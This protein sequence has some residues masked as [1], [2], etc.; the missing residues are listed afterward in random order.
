VRRLFKS[1]ALDREVLRWGERKGRWRRIARGVYG[2]GP[3]DPTPLDL[4]L[5][6]LVRTGGVA[7]GHL[8]G[9]LYGLD[10]VRLRGPD[11]TVEPG[12]SGRGVRRRELANVVVVEGYPCT[13]GLQTLV[14]LAATLDDLKWEQALESAL[15]QQL[16]TID[17]LHTLDRTPARI[18]RVLALRPVGAAATERLL[19]TLMV[20]LARTVEGLP[21]PVRQ[22]RVDDAHARVDLAWPEL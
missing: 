6:V 4:A 2:D 22:Y 8:A 1:D 17:E 5:A 15:R 18:R 13:D 20:Q 16:V 21:D 12:R 9:V 19:E 11:V 7:G 14:D 10:S 3:E